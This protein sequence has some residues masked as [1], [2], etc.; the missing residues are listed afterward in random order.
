M[1]KSMVF[2]LAVFFHSY[3]DKPSPERFFSAEE[4]KAALVI[5]EVYRD[6]EKSSHIILMNGS[7]KPHY[8]DRH[9]FEVELVQGSNTLHVAGMPVNLSLGNKLRVEK[10]SLHWAENTGQG[11]S[12]LSV[13]FYPPF[14][15]KD[16]RFFP[17]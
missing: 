1:R 13:S 6:N 9:S 3:C 12:I 8:H 2:A 16:R 4:K 5:K 15:G 17:N 11:F 10:G 7:E 14:D